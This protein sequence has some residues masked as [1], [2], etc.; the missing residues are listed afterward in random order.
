M[1][2]ASLRTQT[3]APSEFDVAVVVDGVDETEGRYRE[4][5]DQG[6]RAAPSRCW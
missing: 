5:L 1:V 3:L 6:R 4:V 2:L